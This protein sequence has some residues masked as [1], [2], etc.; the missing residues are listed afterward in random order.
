MFSLYQYF[1]AVSRAW[2]A[3]CRRAK[4]LSDLHESQSFALAGLAGVSNLVLFLLSGK[5]AVGKRG[6]ERPPTRLCH[7][8]PKRM[9]Q[10]I[11]AQAAR[12]LCAQHSLDPKRF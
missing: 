9:E 7:R 10:N 3:V 11:R 8:H 5:S 2:C 4:L 1:L 12:T 6:A